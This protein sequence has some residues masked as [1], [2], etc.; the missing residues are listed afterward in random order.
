MARSAPGLL[1]RSRNFLAV[2]KALKSNVL[3]L[4][5]RQKPAVAIVS[6]IGI[7]SSTSAEWRVESIE[8]ELVIKKVEF[9]TEIIK[10]VA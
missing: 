10:K 5:V 1:C 3:P 8:G 6:A 7:S 4:R 9:L 2:N